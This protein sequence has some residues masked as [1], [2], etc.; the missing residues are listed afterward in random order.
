MLYQSIQSSENKKTISSM[1][2]F[3]TK[4]LC[5]ESY[6]LKWSK[7][8]W[9]EPAPD[10]SPARKITGKPRTQHHPR[11]TKWSPNPVWQKTCPK[12]SIS[13]SRR[14]SSMGKITSN[15]RT[16]NEEAGWVTWQEK[17][18]NQ[19][20]KMTSHGINSM[21]PAIGKPYQLLSTAKDVWEAVKDCNSDLEN[22]S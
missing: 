13:N 3:G 21:E 22:S 1:F 6:L 10:P 11:L 12:P 8:P 15:G 5:S 18:S 2:F 9:T 19:K 17:S 16:W 7:Q 14:T 4:T 20:K